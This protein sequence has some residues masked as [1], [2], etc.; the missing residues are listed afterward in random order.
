MR[1]ENVFLNNEMSSLS[2]YL[3][4]IEGISLLS[5]DEELQLAVKAKNGDMVA[6]NKLVEANSRFV[7]SVAK[8]YQGNG[9]DLEDLISEGNIGLLIAVDKFEPEK[10]YRFISYAVW[11]IRQSIM[12]AIN[13]KSRMVRI[14]VNKIGQAEQYEIDV[15]SLDTPVGDDE[16][17]SFGDFIQSEENPEDDVMNQAL[18]ESFDRILAKFPEREREIIVKRYGLNSQKALSLKE[19]GDLYGLTKERIRQIEKKMLLNL[20]ELED[21]K[22][23]KYYIA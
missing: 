19:V 23:L 10:G 8:K 6:R 14:P 21:V 20:S 22:D 7:V 1:K 4:E 11:W 12:K 17:S 9:L 15:C 2:T 5:E 3:K 16:D 18:T 13:D